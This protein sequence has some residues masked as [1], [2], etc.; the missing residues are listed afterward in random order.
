MLGR[1]QKRLR[2]H[3]GLPTGNKS[4]EANSAK[5]HANTQHSNTDP[6]VGSKKP[7]SLT[8]ETRITQPK[9]ET[10]P[11]QDL[12]TRYK[13]ELA[14]LENDERLDALLERAEN[15]ETLSEQE[16]HYIEKTLD[17]IDFLMQKLGIEIDDDEDD[18][19]EKRE[20]IFQLLRQP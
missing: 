14:K 18:Q 17:R 20:D 4:N 1:E 8:S 11:P 3:K 16:E 9:E 6:R 19:D 10:A 12:K 5:H 13:E 7:I 15:G 2:K